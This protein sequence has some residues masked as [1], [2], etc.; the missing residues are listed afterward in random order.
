MGEVGDE[1]SYSCVRSGGMWDNAVP[2]QCC[3]ELETVLKKESLLKKTDLK[4]LIIS[5]LFFLKVKLVK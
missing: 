3:C 4:I 1:G 2:S 5:F